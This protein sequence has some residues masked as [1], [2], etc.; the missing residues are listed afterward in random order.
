[1]VAKLIFIDWYTS[2]RDL[3]LIFPYCVP[4]ILSVIRLLL[5]CHVLTLA[6]YEPT[7]VGLV[8][9]AWDLGV[10]FRDFWSMKMYVVSNHG[11]HCILTKVWRCMWL[12]TMEI[13]AF[14]GTLLSLVIFLNLKLD[15]LE[16]HSYI[17]VD[18]AHH[19][20]WFV[21]SWFLLVIRLT[22][23]TEIRE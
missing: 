18:E 2:C 7:W 3:F 23:Y 22:N 9:L 14:S 8:V 10:C 6:G 1:M 15:K 20:L 16:L 12:V 21:P 11:N 5:H 19:S 13:A 17:G 4:S